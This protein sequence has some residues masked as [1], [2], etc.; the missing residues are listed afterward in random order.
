MYA[1]LLDK[2]QEV[3][4]HLGAGRKGYLHVAKTGGSVLLNG[5]IQLN[6]GDGAFISET[7]DFTIKGTSEKTAEVVLFDLSEKESKFED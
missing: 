4:H 6:E 5:N 7:E 2:D 3:K 1:S